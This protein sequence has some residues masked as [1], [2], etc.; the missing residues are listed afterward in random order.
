VSPE[1]IPGLLGDD[2][3]L[4]HYNV[5][6]KNVAVFVGGARQGLDLQILDLDSE[7]LR[8]EID[9]LLLDLKPRD[10]TLKPVSD[11]KTRLKGLR[12]ELLRG[13]EERLEGARGIIVVPDACLHL[14]PFEAL[15]LEDGSYLVEKLEVR[16]APSL[17]VLLELDRR[18]KREARVNLVL[19]GDPEF[20][21]L[22]RDTE[23]PAIALRVRGGSGFAKLEHA[24]EEVDKIG[25]L[26]DEKVVRRGEEATEATFKAESPRGAL[27]HV[28]THGR[29]AQAGGTDARPLFYSGLAFS[30]CNQGGDG[31]EDGFLSAVEVMGI[32]LRAVDLAV[33][34]ACETSAGAVRPQEGKMGLERAFFLAGVKTFVGSL[35]QVNDRAAA[36]F[37]GN[38]YRCLLEGKTKPQALRQAKLDL[39]LRGRKELTESTTRG[40]RGIGL[41]PTPVRDSSHPYYWAPFVLS[42]DGR[43]GL[44][45]R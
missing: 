20:G 44:R 26:F 15:V 6:G 24:R 7:K 27:L 30:G 37:M 21:K 19:F 8:A 41:A 36:E 1:Q 16:Y 10:R 33:L 11:L 45:R 31:A 2:E 28:A 42:G 38:F 23:E 5:V 13:V 34:S 18:E 3:V 9:E 25:A 43:G 35:W 29:F 39:I 17:Q 4:L 14:F 22:P 12:Q 32:D 40:E